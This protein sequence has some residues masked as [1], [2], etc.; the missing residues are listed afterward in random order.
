MPPRVC[1]GSWGGTG[2]VTC[3]LEKF[4]SALFCGFQA[5]QQKW[6]RIWLEIFPQD[7]GLNRRNINL[8]LP[9]RSCNPNWCESIIMIYQSVFWET[10]GIHGENYDKPLTNS[11]QKPQMAKNFD[12]RHAKSPCIHKAPIWGLRHVFW[13]WRIIYTSK[14]V[15]SYEIDNQN[16]CAANFQLRPLPNLITTQN[17][18]WTF[19]WFSF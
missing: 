16:S 12:P 5:V 4:R 10:V 8:K 2:R 11:P 9:P 18:I 14:R 3:G 7:F 15:K 17:T 19:Q 1:P 6:N 13:R